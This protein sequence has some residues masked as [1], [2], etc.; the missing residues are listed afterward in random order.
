MVLAKD[1]HRAI[2]NGKAEPWTDLEKMRRETM[3]VPETQLIA[4]LF[5]LMRAERAHMACVV[6][7]YGSFVGIITLEDLIEEIVGEIEDETDDARPSHGIKQIDDSTWEIDGLTALSDIERVIGFEV[8][9]EVD[10]N[11]INGYFMRRLARMPQIGDVVVESGFELQVM[12]QDGH[13]VGK[14]RITR[15]DT[16]TAEDK[17]AENTDNKDAG[18]TGQDADSDPK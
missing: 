16:E 15:E 11:T 2:L 10:A 18:N 1:I 17:D 7:E 12:E 14:V 6:D 8:S 4:K 3:V 5:D 9:D 13:R